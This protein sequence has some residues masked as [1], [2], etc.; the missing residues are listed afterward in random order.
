MRVFHLPKEMTTVW[1]TFSMSTFR[2]EEVTYFITFTVKCT[3]CIIFFNINVYICSCN[4]ICSVFIVCS[5]SFI[6]CVVLCALFCLS[7]VCYFV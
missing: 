5:V 2:N 6:V 3:A 1:P 4:C 7:E